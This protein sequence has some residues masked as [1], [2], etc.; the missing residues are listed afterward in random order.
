MP[1]THGWMMLRW[2]GVFTLLVSSGGLAQAAEPQQP[3]APQVDSFV[4]LPLV[5]RG[6]YVC[7]ATST[8]SYYQNV[9]YRAETPPIRPAEGHADK[10]FALR[11]FITITTESKA[12]ITGQADPQESHQPPQIGTI[13]TPDRVTNAAANITQVYHTYLWNWGTYPDPGSRGGE[14]SNPAVGVLGLGATPGEVLQAPTSY[15]EIAFVNNKHYQAFVMYADADT[16]ALHYSAEDSVV[17][18]YTVHI[19]N[20]CTDPNLLALYNSLDGGGTGPRYTNTSFNMPY[21]E[22]GQAIGTARDNLVRVKVVD[23]GS[24]IEPR[25]CWNLWHWTAPGANGPCN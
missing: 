24:T 25:M 16:I 23:T 3:K 14:D 22:V 15:Y 10:N 21:V 4:Y 8:N 12:L 9:I 13:F 7:P 6:G 18:G 11:G 5:S 17:N 2:V 19:D 1:K 20:I